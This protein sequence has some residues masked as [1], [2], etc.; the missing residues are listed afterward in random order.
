MIQVFIYTAKFLNPVNK[1][2]WVLVVFARKQTSQLRL[3]K[4]RHRKAN[5]STKL[6]K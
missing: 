1:E 5:K 4:D 2:N 6:K 3:F